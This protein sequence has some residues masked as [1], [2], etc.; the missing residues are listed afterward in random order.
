MSATAQ[1]HM[2]AEEFLTWVMDQP[3]DK[4]YEL[5]AGEVV[6]MAPERAAHARAKMR[7][8]VQFAV[9]IKAAN[10]ACEAFGDGMAVRVDTDTIFEPDALIRRG[11]PL[12]DDAI[13][14]T[15][16]VV[17]T[18]VVSPSSR[19]QDAGKKLTAYFRIP[20][21]RHYLIVNTETQLITHHRRD[22]AGNI[23]KH[24]IRDGVLR[25]DPPGL[26]VTGLFA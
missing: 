3:E 6:A 5:F 22:E 8:A 7:F 4:R 11:Q 17:V 15:D 25:L 13:V 19:R 12:S 23:T 21:L 16:P 9:A 20:S 26:A 24:I 10:L 18:E 1:K 2:T 14:I